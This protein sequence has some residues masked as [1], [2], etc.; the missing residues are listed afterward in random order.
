M[1]FASILENAKRAVDLARQAAGLV[2][3]VRENL[4]RAKETLS[5]DQVDELKR[6]I[7]ELHPINMQLSQTLDEKLV[8]AE[9]RV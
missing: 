6:T 4:D 7:D 2:S 1:D 9:K 3:T 8:L 5:A